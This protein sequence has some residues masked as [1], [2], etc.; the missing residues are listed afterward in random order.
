MSEPMGLKRD[1]KKEKSA[2]PE[3]RPLKI[4]CEDLTET[5]L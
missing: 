1:I 2:W 5:A 4:Q 3:L